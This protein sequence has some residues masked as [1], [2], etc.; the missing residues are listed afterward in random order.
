M[1]N[2]NNSVIYKLCSK[3]VNI[4]EIYVGST[5]NNLRVRKGQHK[6]VCNNINSHCYNSYVYQ[7][8]RNNGGFNNW[9]IVEIEKYPCNDKQEL[10]K[11]ERFYIELLGST[12]NSNLPTRS[13]K[14]Y[15]KEYR[16]N[17][18]AKLKE[19]D[20]QRYQ[21]NKN[22]ILEQQK[23]Y[24][25]KNKNK[26]KEF[27]KTNKDKLLKQMKEYYKNNKDKLLEKQKEYDLNNKDKKKEKIECD[28]CNKILSR[29]SLYLHKKNL[30]K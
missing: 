12:L 9:D 13:P 23:E 6:A 25:Q 24:H 29:G 22:E 27:Y 26:S 21:N 2:Y 15:I 1:I 14:E 10:H 11:R 4:T 20:K 28:I 3:D 30:H 7:F 8:I 18:K 16:E 5:A 19:Y 17:N